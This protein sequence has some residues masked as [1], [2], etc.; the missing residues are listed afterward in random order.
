LVDVFEKLDES[1]IHD[2]FDLFQVILIPVADLYSI[3]P[4]QIVQLLLAGA[5]IRSATGYQS[6]YFRVSCNQFVCAVFEVVD[7]I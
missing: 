1:F 6:M 7:S 3:I 4:E 5:I 2:L